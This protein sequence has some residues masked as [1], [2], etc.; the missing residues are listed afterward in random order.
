MTAKQGIAFSLEGVDEHTF[1]RLL[2][3]VTQDSAFA[4]PLQLQA[5]PPKSGEV[6][7]LTIAFE[8]QDRTKAI[9]AMQRLKTIILRYGVQVDSIRVPGTP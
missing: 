1:I 4:R 8:P 9:A 3:D 5:Q 6:G 2:N 7:R